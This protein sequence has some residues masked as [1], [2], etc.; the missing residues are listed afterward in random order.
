MSKKRTTYKYKSFDPATSRNLLVII[1]QTLPNKQGAE[2][3]YH[4]MKN[5]DV[6][7]CVALDPNA[8]E[9]GADLYVKVPVSTNSRGAG[10]YY[11]PGKF[12]EDL[13]KAVLRDE[14]TKYYPNYDILPHLL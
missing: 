5:G 10:P 14:L 11:C 3:D 12:R 13:D 4:V 8:Y 1:T 7:V 6:W 9:R 2:Q